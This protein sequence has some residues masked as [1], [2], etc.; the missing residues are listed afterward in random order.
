MIAAAR[1]LLAL[2]LLAVFY[3]LVAAMVLLWGAFLAAALWTAAEPGVQTPPMSVVTACA[4]FA[5]I[6]FGMVWAVIRTA[7]PAV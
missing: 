4:A 1:A 2:A 3:A 7:R 6:V 5:P